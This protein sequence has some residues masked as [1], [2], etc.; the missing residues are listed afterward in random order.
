MTKEVV[1]KY[2]QKQKSIFPSDGYRMYFI[3]NHDENSWNG[4]VAELLDSMFDPTVTYE[5]LKWIRS[6]WQGNLVVKGIQNDV[7]VSSSGP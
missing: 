6:Q 3:D 4:T 5:D 1:L 2:L 7:W